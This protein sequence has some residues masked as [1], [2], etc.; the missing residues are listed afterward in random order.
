M[1]PMRG[2]WV[3]LAL[4]ACGDDGNTTSDALADGIGVDEGMIDAPDPFMPATLAETGLCLDA[5]C[6]QIASGIHEFAPRFEL[7][8]DTAAKKRWIYLPSG[9]TIDTSDMDAWQFPVG[10]KLWKEFARDGTRVETRLV[11]R[12]G[13]GTTPQ[14]WFYAAYVWNATQ[15]ATHWAEFGEPNAN[16]T[17]HDVPGKALC[18]QCHENVKPSRVLGFSALQLD[19]DNTATGQLDLEDLITMSLLSA[20]P[21]RASTAEPFFPFDAGN[22]ASVM[23]ALGYLHANCSHCHNPTSA[24]IN[25]TPLNLKLTVGTVGATST[26]S[27]YVTAV[28]VTTLNT[29]NGHNTIVYKGDPDMSVMMDRFRATDGNRMPA[30]GTEFKDDVGEPILEAWITNIPP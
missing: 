21:T 7:Y 2:T 29:I 22:H 16:G 19:W 9:M 10:T 8:S 24:V 1:A 15:D 30:A 4:C 25:N 11:W 13:A 28:N 17:E 14:D 27:A 3:L 26:T 6:T 5:G 20:P 12:I 18:R 23:P